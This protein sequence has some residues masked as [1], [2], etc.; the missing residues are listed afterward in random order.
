[1]QQILFATFPEEDYQSIIE[2]LQINFVANY[3]LRPRSNCY[4]GMYWG[5][6]V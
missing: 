3:H 4:Q 5:T 2:T 6:G 1:L